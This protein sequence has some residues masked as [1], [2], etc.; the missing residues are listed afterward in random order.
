MH[1]SRSLNSPRH[2]PY[3]WQ[4]CCAGQ[5]STQER[6]EAKGSECKSLFKLRNTEIQNVC[7]LI[8]KRILRLLEEMDAAKMAGSASDTT[9][10]EASSPTADTVEKAATE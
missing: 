3:R 10:V 1:D 6:D 9:E 5:R 4:A 8:Q 7:V 2:I